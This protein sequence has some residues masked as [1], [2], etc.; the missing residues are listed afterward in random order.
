MRAREQ[1]SESESERARERESESEKTRTKERERESE[2]ESEAAKEE[3]SNYLQIPILTRKLVEQSTPLPQARGGSD[4]RDSAEGSRGD[5]ANRNGFDDDACDDVES[6][7]N[8]GS[9]DLKDSDGVNDDRGFAETCNSESISDHNGGVWDY[10]NTVKG[11]ARG[12][13]NSGGVGDIVEGANLIML[14]KAWEIKELRMRIWRMTSYVKQLKKVNYGIVVGLKAARSELRRLRKTEGERRRNKSTAVVKKNLRIVKDLVTEKETVC[15]STRLAPTADSSSAMSTRLEVEVSSAAD[16]KNVL[17]ERADS[18]G[19]TTVE[20]P[21]RVVLFDQLSKRQT[22]AVVSRAARDVARRKHVNSRRRKHKGAVHTTFRAAVEMR[23]LEATDVGGARLVTTAVLAVSTAPDVSSM[24]SISSALSSSALN[25]S[26][27]S[28]SSIEDAHVPMPVSAGDILLLS[29][30]EGVETRLPEAT[31]ASSEGTVVLGIIAG[32]ELLVLATAE[33]LE[34]T[35][36]DFAT[37]PV[38]PDDVDASTLVLTAAA[39]DNTPPSEAVDADAEVLVFPAVLEDGTS[40]STAPS[41][42]GLSMASIGST[43][44]PPALSS[45]SSSMALTDSTSSS[46]TLIGAVLED[47]AFTLEKNS[48]EPSS[49]VKLKADWASLAPIRVQTD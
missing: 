3:R 28:M 6:S 12:G 7:G 31:D 41:S 4:G 8:G 14:L 35:G 5:G 27:S 26:S 19:L 2:N 48:N 22:R 37:N 24:A 1:E 40:S 25:S 32:N 29:S 36:F 46:P 15:V 21:Q 16:S 43:L 20:G 42:V 44:S 9:G 49:P 38:V 10:V 11:A 13:N 18:A 39:N 23:L 34:G 47:V 45:A 33:V 17:A 30:V